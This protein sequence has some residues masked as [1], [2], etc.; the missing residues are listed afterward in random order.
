MSGRDWPPRSLRGLRRWLSDTSNLTH[1]S[2]LVFAPFLVIVLIEL[3]VLSHIS[4]LLFPPLAAAT[5]TLF[6]EPEDIYSELHRVTVGLWIG[7]FVGW[8]MFELIGFGGVSAGLA[9]FF[10]GIVTWLTGTEHPSAFSTSILAVVLRTDSFVYVVAVI[11]STS[12]V[13]AVFYLWKTRFFERR[14]SI[15]YEST[16]SDDR[17]LVPV[18][19]EAG[20]E[21]G[22][23]ARIAGAHENGQ[24]VLVQSVEDASEEAADRLE[25]LAAGIRE[26]HDLRVEVA[27]VQSDRPLHADLLE[28]VD[29]Y[30]CDSV[31]L[32]WQRR[33]DID[34]QPLFD[35]RVDVMLLCADGPVERV[36][37]VLVPVPEDRRLSHVLVDIGLRVTEGTVCIS[38]MIGSEDD[39]R[40][41]EQRV[42]DII[43]GFDGS[44]ETRVANTGGSVVDLICRESTEYDLVVMGQRPAGQVPSDQVRELADRLDRPL[45][46]I[47]TG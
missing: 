34:L 4:Y 15:L 11:V 12:F 5:F 29:R 3:G 17:I 10:T 13:A 47:E 39:R 45:L 42:L 31:F 46:V 35:H 27:V 24:L 33:Q 18:D 6:F 37:D 19:T 38:A 8:L 40:P 20:P 26:E 25:E 2:V 7:A 44:F 28:V 23:P 14:S 41:T 36:H 1:F 16:W 22:L 21:L 43:D 30:D 32:S 9:I